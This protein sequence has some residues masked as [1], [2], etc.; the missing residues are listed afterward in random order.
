[1]TNE[2]YTIT[3]TAGSGGTISPSGAVTVAYGS[4]KTFT[5]TANIGYHVADVL[6]DGVSVGAVSTY[7][8][9]N[10]T[11]DHTISASFAINTYTVTASVVKPAGGS[12][13]PLSQDVNHSGTATFTVTTNTGYTASVSEGSLVG[14]IWTIPN[15]T[16]TRTVTV[17]FTINTYTVTPSAGAG[18]SIDPSTL[19]TVNHGSTVHFTLTA[20]T[21]YHIDSVI[22]CEGTLAGNLYTTGPITA[23][24]SVTATF[25]IDTF[26]VSAS[27]SGG[28]GTVSPASQTVDY[29]GSA[30]INIFPN[31][32]YHIA[33]T[34]DNGSPV[35]I[36]NPYVISNVTDAHT[37]VVTFA[38]DTHTLSVTKEGT[39]SG[40]VTS[41]PTGIDCGS[42]CSEV[43]DYG[44]SVT[45]TA[46]P[47]VSSTFSGWSGACTGTDPCT[48]TM[49]ADKSVIATFTLNTYT[50]TAT[51]GA[52]GA[53][54]P[55]GTVTVNHGASQTFTITP[56]DSDYMIQEVLVDGVPVEAVSPYTFT[57]VT[58]GH[59]I[60]AT[61]VL[62]PSVDQD[63][64]GVIDSS[65]NCPE[66]TN[67][68]QKDSDADG[69]GD[70]CDNCP[71][72]ANPG[73]EDDDGD[74]LGDSC[75]A[76][77]SETMPLPPPARPGE[78]LPISATFTNNTSQPI[79]TIKPDCYNTTFTVYSGTTPLLPRDR[80]WTAYGIG[81]P[82]TAGSDVTIIDPGESFTVNCDLSDMYDP[83]VLTTGNYTVQ[84]TYSNY[85]QDPDFEDNGACDNPPCYDLWMGAIHSAAAPLSIAPATSFIITPS[86]G[87]NG[88]ISPSTAQIVS[89][90][91]AVS[92]TINPHTNYIVQEVLLDGV[93]IEVF[94][95]Y[96]FT[97][98]TADHTISVSF[99]L[100]PELDDDGDGVLNSIDNC[101]DAH[102]PDQKDS[103]GDG[104]GDACDNCPKVANPGQEDTDNGGLGDGL[105]DACDSGITETMLPPA[106]APPGGSLPISA[107]FTNNTGQAIQTIKPDCYNTTFTVY[108]GTTPLLPRDRVWT[109][110]GI[111]NDVITIPAGQSFTV[112]CDLSDMYDPEVLTTGNY[113]VQ[114]TYSNYI[115]DPDLEDNGTCDNS[116]CYD[117][118]MG[119]IR[120]TEATIEVLPYT[121]TITATAGSGGSISPSGTVTVNHGASQTFTITPNMGYH[122][123]DVLVDGSSVGAVTSYTF[124]NVT[125]NHTI[126][127]SF[128]ADTQTYLLTVTK[129]GTGSGNVTASPGTLVWD[130][131]IGTASYPQGTRVTLT[132]TPNTGSSFTG[133]SAYCSGSGNC[134]VVISGSTCTVNMCG[135]CRATATFTAKTYT[136]TATAGTGGKISPSGKVKVNHGASQTFTITPN[137]RYKIKDVKVDG[138]SVGPVSSYTFN[139]VTANHK[140]YATFVR[141]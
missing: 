13:T 88:S 73:Q 56:L 110:Y 63:G 80:V 19:Q 108:S 86:A 26:I 103:D 60:S 118:W 50:I 114:A 59:T 68:D 70:A 84:A 16:S 53:I 99:V 7:E 124:N 126:S 95:S 111:P 112:D 23:D 58:A 62:S 67:P 75:D 36:A 90:G 21:G 40:S 14:T 116:P 48:R 35:S 76:G 93:P 41:V 127:A 102:N 128:A 131:N 141:K 81:A 47:D 27:V 1:M 61:F 129:A 37:V 18:G 77:I 43:Y 22:G 100:D 20:D 133:W 5:I 97:N 130:G 51:A 55:S 42:D 31:T 105:G 135:P 107:T 94:T 30:T 132:A 123:T 136:I 65:D 71:K 49:D 96:T 98:V 52:N 10:V 140:I 85:I 82:D 38:I 17:T 46:A 69:I 106:P 115:Q 79:W 121:H 11:A 91:G 72:N 34:T 83:E 92:F 87:T 74:G 24:C 138:V 78:S 125:A 33:S 134:S 4:P 39:G 29:N 89:S 109:A 9:T 117:L 122:V 32:G 45:L 54:S 28:N 104:I 15:V 64:D 25:A 8:F 66:V 101:P 2:F 113:T 44:T 120:S 139:N 3:A 12:V 137:S 57:N 119:A 6:V